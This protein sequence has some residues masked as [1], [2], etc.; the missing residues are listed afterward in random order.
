MHFEGRGIAFYYQYFT[1][2]HGSPFWRKQTICRHL[3]E[4]VGST[5]NRRRSL[6]EER[7]TNFTVRSP[8]SYRPKLSSALGQ[9]YATQHQKKKKKMT[10][11]PSAAS[12]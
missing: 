5:S 4:D 6:G 10:L 1:D 7:R 2:A 8:G 3:A 9:M 12:Q 11:V